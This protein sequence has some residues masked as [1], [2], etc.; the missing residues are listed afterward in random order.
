M[1]EVRQGTCACMSSRRPSTSTVNGSH[2]F[3]DWLAGLLRPRLAG[4]NCPPPVW[5]DMGSFHMKV[6]FFLGVQEARYIRCQCVAGHGPPT[7]PAM[8]APTCPAMHGL[9]IWSEAAVQGFLDMAAGHDH[10]IALS[11]EKVLRSLLVW[12]GNNIDSI[13]NLVWIRQI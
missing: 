2:G 5:V 10:R 1:C 12:G 7:C 8:T 3:L 6:Q 9:E 11:A 13:S 4:Q